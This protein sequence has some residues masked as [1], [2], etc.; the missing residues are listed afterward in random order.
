MK[1]ISL[2]QTVLTVF[3]VVALLVSNII[4]NKQF[5]VGGIVLP[6]AVF[7][8]PIVYILSDVFSEV[9]GYR[10]SRITCWM[11]LAANLFMVGFFALTIA[12]PYPEYFEGQTAFQ[13]VLG[14]TPKALFASALALCVGDW[15]NDLVF[16]KMKGNKDLKGFGLRAILSS[17]V[18]EIADSCICLPIIFLGTMPITAIIQ[19]IVFQVLAKVGYEIV[20]LPLTT[21]VVKKMSGLE[22]A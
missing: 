20:I 10:W 15:L 18:G 19:M 21:F 17:L 16:Q 9:Y 4:V 8:F 12:L 5:T 7:I 6:A 3:Y 22:L 11:A 13:A 2:R 14:S 1:K